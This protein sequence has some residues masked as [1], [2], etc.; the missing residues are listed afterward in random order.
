MVINSGL[1]ILIIDLFEG[2]LNGDSGLKECYSNI[3][4]MKMCKI[5][6]QHNLSGGFIHPK[7]IQAVHDSSFYNQNIEDTPL[8]KQFRLV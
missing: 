6:T 8:I 1:K 3:D 2:L 4:I 7:Y 5:K